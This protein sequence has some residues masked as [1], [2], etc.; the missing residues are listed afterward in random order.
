MS[1]GWSPDSASAERTYD[2]DSTGIFNLLANLGS[3]H[4]N[5]MNSPGSSMD[6][7]DRVEELFSVL[8]ETHHLFLL[9]RCVWVHQ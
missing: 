1:N 7:W 6:F 8:G 9:Q 5:D 4:P 2:H 3:G